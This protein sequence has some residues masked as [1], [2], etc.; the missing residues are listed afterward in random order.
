MSLGLHLRVL[1]MRHGWT[2]VTLSKRSGVSEATIRAIEAD[3]P[4]GRRRR[5]AT[6]AALSQALGL[7]DE[8]L[9]SYQDNPPPEDLAGGR[10]WPSVIGAIQDRVRAGHISDAELL[11]LLDEIRQEISDGSVA[12]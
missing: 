12:G 6:L 1:R 8:H 5:H 7:P 11:D 10:D 2:Q 4:N 3:Y 9:T